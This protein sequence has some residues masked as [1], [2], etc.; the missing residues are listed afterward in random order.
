MALSAAF[1]RVAVSDQVCVGPPAQARSN[2]LLGKRL[3]VRGL[4]GEPG[5]ASQPLAI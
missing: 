5:A 2:P 1:A 3:D 4:Q